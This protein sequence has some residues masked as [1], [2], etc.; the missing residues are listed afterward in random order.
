MQAMD[1]P[2]WQPSKERIA[3]A[4]MTAFARALA[5]AH[6]EGLRSYPEL[7][8]WSRPPKPMS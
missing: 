1:Q 7:R 5:E 3:R 8:A 6:G 2:L 4:N